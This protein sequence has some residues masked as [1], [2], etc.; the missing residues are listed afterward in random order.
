MQ[1]CNA[2]KRNG[3]E[4]WPIKASVDSK[5]YCVKLIGGVM[6]GKNCAFI[7]CHVYRKKG[8]LEYI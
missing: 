1:Q 4:K 7:E 2:I 6:P 5:C 3:R 8:S